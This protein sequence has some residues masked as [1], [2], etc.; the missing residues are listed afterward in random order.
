MLEVILL[1]CV[2]IFLPPSEG[3]I[4]WLV[5]AVAII[6]PGAYATYTGAPFVPTSQKT[7]RKMIELAKIKKG[8]KVY[9]LGCGDG[10]LVFAAAKKGANAVG[11]EFSVP[12]FLWAKI[13]SLIYPRSSIQLRDFWKQNYKDADVIFCYLLTDTMQVFK[14][15]VWPQLKPGTRVVSHAFRMK[16]IQPVKK[17]DGVVLYMKR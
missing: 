7:L 15:K 17:E 12:T 1:L 10:R 11:Y 16:D 5:L 13:R 2:I 9:D 8:E 6:I 14:K 4:L 3:N